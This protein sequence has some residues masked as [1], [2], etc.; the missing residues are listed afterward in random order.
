MRKFIYLLLFFCF[1]ALSFA[2]QNIGTLTTD[3][4]LQIDGQV[5]FRN[6]HLVDNSI[7]DDSKYSRVVAIDSVGNVGVK[8]KDLNTKGYYLSGH[9]T[10]LMT[11]G[12]VI[13]NAGEN[14]KNLAL[15]KLITFPSMTDNIIVI[16]YSLPTYKTDGKP[17]ATVGISIRMTKR[18][19]GTSNDTPVEGA[20]RKN[21]FP[22][23]FATT[24]SDKNLGMVINGK[25]VETF[26]N[27]LSVNRKFTYKL[28]A[29]RDYN[30]GILVIGNTFGGINGSGISKENG[31]GI[32]IIKVY[33]KN[34]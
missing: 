17:G 23:D 12:A 3:G 31:N 15:D 19:L 28:T 4:K 14:G 16:S 34:L 25:W 29:W 8:I 22:E 33:S 5:A 13:I 1:T 2:Q 26:Q 24:G 6:Q 21:T 20:N 30:G 9:Y 32:L 18:E 10:G 7:V 11:Y 27:D